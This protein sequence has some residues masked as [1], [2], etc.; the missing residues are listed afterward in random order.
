[1]TRQKAQADTRVSH[2]RTLSHFNCIII[3]SYA[4]AANQGKKRKSALIE[5][6]NF[7]DNFVHFKQSKEIKEDC[8]LSVQLQKRDKTGISPPQI[9]NFTPIYQAYRPTVTAKSRTE[10]ADHHEARH[11]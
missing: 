9:H 3:L 5:L 10:Q 6:R 8:I 2:R 11:V 4:R 7:E 1:M